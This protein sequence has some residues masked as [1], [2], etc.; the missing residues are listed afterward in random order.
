MTTDRTGL[1]RK[2]LLVLSSTFPRW[3]GDCEPPFVFE[4]CRRLVERFD[5]LVLAPHGPGA[6]PREI[7]S[8]VEVIRF[9]YFFAPWERL[10]YQ[11]G[12]L[13]N[14]R[15]QP[16][17][18]LLVPFFLAAQLIALLRL[19]RHERIDVIHAHW[20]IPQ[21]LIALA[22]RFLHRGS[23]FPAWLCTS[24]GSDLLGLRGGLFAALKRKVLRHADA[25]TVVSRP[26]RAH[27]LTLGADG[28][29][30]SV[31]PMGIDMTNLFVPM[32]ATEGHEPELLFVGRLVASKAVDV[33][34]GAMPAILAGCPAATLTIVGDGPEKARLEAA[35]KALGVAD[36]VTFLGAV[37]NPALPALYRRAAI[38]VS[39]SLEEGFGL[40]LVEAM[41]CGCAVIASDLPAT[42]DIVVDGE[43]G[44]TVPPGDST[45]IAR[46][47]LSLLADAALRH[48]L[49][50]AGRAFVQKQ[51]D[52]DIVA[53][54]YGYLLDELAPPSRQ[55]SWE[56]P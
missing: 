34:I 21:G 23:R 50:R 22:A 44:L 53:G 14:L 24:H 2:R 8:G 37:A 13:A 19:L 15:Q 5:V 49:G 38:F 32:P 39:P 45:A 43:T 26:M 27:A 6:K 12:I 54:R 36:R 20:L 31:I 18:Y 16:I 3:E 48:S 17:R 47:A 9:R 4:L 25:V 35:A 28:R 29:K 46:A 11:G 41:A 51:F 10:A 33:L 56:H 1:R 42:R 40:T 52:W 7:L 30:L 55:P